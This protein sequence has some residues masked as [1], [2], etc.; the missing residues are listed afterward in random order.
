[1]KT[2]IRNLSAY[3]VQSNSVSLEIQAKKGNEADEIN[4]WMGW[5]RKGNRSHYRYHEGSHR[6]KKYNHSQ[7]TL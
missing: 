3:Y 1:M 5:K 6:M 2:T 7:H 4:I